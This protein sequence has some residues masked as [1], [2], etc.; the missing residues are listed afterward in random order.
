MNNLPFVSIVLPTY[1]RKGQLL[2]CFQTLEH[3]TYPRD[4]FEVIVVDDGSTDGTGE[5]I[6]EY[7]KNSKLKLSY[8]Y[9]ESAGPGVARNL[10]VENAAGGI[11]GFIEDDVLAEK[12]WI[13]CAVKYFLSS[14]IAAVEGRTMFEDSGKSI[15]RFESEQRVGFLPCN[16]FIRREVFTSLGKFDAAFFDSRRNLYFREDADFGFRLIQQGYTFKVAEDVIVTHPDPY[17]SIASYFRHVRRYFF[18]PLL[19]K[20][21]PI[22]Y[23]KL[24]EVKNIGPIIIHRPFHYLCFGYMFV[25]AWTIGAV[26][27]GWG[28]HTVVGFLLMVFTSFMIRLRYERKLEIFKLSKTFAFLVLPFYY[29][30]NFLRGCFH[31]KSW[32]SLF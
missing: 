19:Y 18:D 17:P 12:T 31:F 4:K 9:Q 23:R 25:V 7:Q 16:M 32:G 20:K 2:R 6:K 14:D 26:L 28:W 30:Y 27:F 15:R 1:H 22:Q 21:H 13:E 3:Q 5:A 11:I 29:C 24:I 8:Y 10:G